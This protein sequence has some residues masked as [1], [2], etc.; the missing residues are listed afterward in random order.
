ML[1]I[2]LHI[3]SKANFPKTDGGCLKVGC[4]ILIEAVLILSRGTS[5]QGMK[6]KVNHYLK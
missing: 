1:K 3:S 5:K 2:H 6:C 4:L